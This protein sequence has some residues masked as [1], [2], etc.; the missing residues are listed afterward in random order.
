MNG[1]FKGPTHMP[2]GFLE[3][4]QFILDTNEET[5]W[6]QYGTSFIGECMETVY[7]SYFLS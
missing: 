5:R 2:I 6:D 7:V 3:D 4:T 1:V